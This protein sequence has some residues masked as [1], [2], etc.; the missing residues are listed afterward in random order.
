MRDAAAEFFF[1]EAFRFPASQA[2]VHHFDGNTNLLAKAVGKAG[3]F[4]GHVTAG[5]IEA[6]GE[7]D[8]DLLDMMIADELAETAHVLVAVDA[9]EGGVWFGDAGLGVREGQADFVAAVVEC[10]DFGRQES[11]FGNLSHKVSIA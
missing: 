2:L 10:E 11:G 7:A 5:A 3:G 8:D 1:E 6:E 9:L 4:L